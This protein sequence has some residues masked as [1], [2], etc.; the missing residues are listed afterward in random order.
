MRGRIANS[1]LRMWLLVGLLI[2]VLFVLESVA[3]HA[4]FAT[5]FPGCSDFYSRWAGARALLLE[6]RDPYSLEVTAEIQVVIGVDPAYEGKGGFAYPLYVLFL[7][8]PL[9][10]C[11]YDWTQAVWMVTLQWMAV[12][13][14]AGL[15]RLGRWRPS[16]VGLARLFLGTLFFYPVARTIMLGQFTLHVTFF[17][18]AALWALQRGSDD[19]AGVWL[20]AASV[21]PQMVVFII[22]WLVLWAVGQRRWR[23]VRGL[24]VGG[25]QLLLA[26]LALFPRW[27]ISFLEDVQRYSKVASG[28]N[29][30]AVMMGLVWPGGPEAVRY[31]L[32]GLLLLAMLGA[33]WR[34]WRDDGKFFVRAIHWT[35]ITS[36]LV[37]FQTGTTNQVLLLIPLF[38]WLQEALERWGRWR[39]LIGVSSLLV[40]L[41]GLFLSTISGNLEDPVMFLPL[42]FLSLAV[43]IGIEISHWRAARR[44]AVF[45]GFGSAR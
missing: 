26:S 9:V 41:W 24:L 42:L 7:F 39:V 23:L 21:K 12:A 15:L 29:P 30:L 4:F 20:A 31:G 38:T 27:P 35:I 3:V 33:W 18:V 2:G 32:V 37:T 5:L 19:W 6:G 28:R 17:L 16:P 34:G 36:L 43:L 45:S 40:A 14:V 8:W 10:Y 25:G 13:T 22:P 1:R 44:Q 11:S